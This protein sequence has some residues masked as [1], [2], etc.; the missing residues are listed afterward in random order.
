MER[1]RAEDL[2]GELPSYQCSWLFTISME[3]RNRQVPNSLLKSLFGPLTYAQA[4]IHLYIPRKVSET[5]GKANS[6]TL[7]INTLKLHSL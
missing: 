3:E 7:M 5:Q 4:L 2:G 6:I 1:P